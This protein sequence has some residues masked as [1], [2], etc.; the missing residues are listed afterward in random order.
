MKWIVRIMD[1]LTAYDTFRGDDPGR[2]DEP[3]ETTREIDS[4]EFDTEAE[5]LDFYTR[6]KSALRFAGTA[7][8]YVTYP[9]QNT[10]SK[11]CK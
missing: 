3:H 1:N 5:A 7:G 9:V 8:M 6:R 11:T 2:E 4:H 10:D